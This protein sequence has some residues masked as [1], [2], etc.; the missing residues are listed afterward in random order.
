LDF[1]K[2]LQ[3]SFS[4]SSAAFGAKAFIVRIGAIKKLVPNLEEESAVEGTVH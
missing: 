3:G 2:L 4:F 1:A